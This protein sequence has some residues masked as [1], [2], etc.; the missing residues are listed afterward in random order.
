[1]FLVQVFL[2]YPF[3]FEQH[4]RLKPS[5]GPQEQWSA[6]RQSF[7]NEM[8]EF[9]AHAIKI[10]NTDL[11]CR[12]VI[13][14]KYSSHYHQV[15]VESKNKINFKNVVHITRASSQHW[16]AAGTQ[17]EAGKLAFHLSPTRKWLWEEVFSGP[18]HLNQLP[19]G[20]VCPYSII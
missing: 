11:H 7:V 18:A 10:L 13:L 15:H 3:P 16:E 1:M 4:R 8:W 19:R 17:K 14:K 6:C 9:V 20:I 5:G 12:L 2:N